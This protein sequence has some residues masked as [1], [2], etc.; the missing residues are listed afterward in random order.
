MRRTRRGCMRGLLSGRLDAFSELLLELRDALL[1]VRNA[2]PK[3]RQLAVD[4]GR[5]QPLP[6]INRWIPG[7][8]PSRIDRVRDPG[9]GRRQDAF[10]E[11][12]MV[13]D[14]DLSRKDHVVFDDA[15]PGDPDLR[16]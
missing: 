15:A 12:D 6:M 13:G 2:F 9:L 16:R 4:G 11:P 7:N 1:E 10:S 8:V 14:T 3:R 5:L